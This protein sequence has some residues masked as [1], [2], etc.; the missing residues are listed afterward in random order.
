MSYEIGTTG[1][2]SKFTAAANTAEVI[3]ATEKYARR[4]HMTA[5]ETNT[6]IVVIGDATVKAG[7]AGDAAKARIGFVLSPGGGLTIESVYLNKLYVASV[8]LGEGVTFTY[9]K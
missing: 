8:V 4:V 2:G 3:S 7:A 1:S 5:H 9:E 6:D